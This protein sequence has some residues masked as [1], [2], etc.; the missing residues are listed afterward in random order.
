MEKKRAFSN[1]TVAMEGIPTKKKYHP[2]K[3]P[4]FPCI[5][6]KSLANANGNDG[7]SD[8]LTEARTSLR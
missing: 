6:L 3:H 5:S 7:A 4:A 2:S 1:K 8:V